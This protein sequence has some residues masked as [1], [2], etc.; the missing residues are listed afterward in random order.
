MTKLS[1]KIYQ[2]IQHINR[3]VK[4]NLRRKGFIYPVKKSDGTVVVGNYLI[5]KNSNN[6][7]DIFDKNQTIILQDINLA[8]SAILIANELA[9][10][11]CVNS[12]KINVDRQYG[13]TMFD[14]KR[15]DH[16]I[17]SLFKKQNFDRLDLMIAKKSSAMFKAK[18]L[19]SIIQSDYEK[20]LQLDK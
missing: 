11:N 16:S 2:K 19:K 12:V 10:T 7:F 3:D 18:R 13:Y 17:K 1:N 20:L 6:F 4:D 14:I 9:L 8:E 15:Y 5:K